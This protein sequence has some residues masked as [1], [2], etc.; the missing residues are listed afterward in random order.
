MTF[1]GQAEQ[2]KAFLRSG[3]SMHA[4][5]VP[6]PWPYCDLIRNPYDL[7]SGG[8]L[9]GAVLPHGP[10]I[11]G[12]DG[13]S[14][15]RSTGA[16]GNGSFQPLPRVLVEVWSKGHFNRKSQANF[17][18]KLGCS[19]LGMPEIVTWQAGT[20]KWRCQRVTSPEVAGRL[21]H[22]LWMCCLA[23]AACPAWGQNVCNSQR[24]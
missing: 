11:A 5:N 4:L 23:C 18:K 15:S 1:R 20:Q 13:I 9:S 14:L 8:S 7:V 2:Y 6:C 24:K 16:S 10:K 21:F 12:S 22:E 3:S 17:D 19:P